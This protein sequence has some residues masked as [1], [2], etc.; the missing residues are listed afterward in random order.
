MNLVRNP[1]A[2]LRH[3]A[4][5]VTRI[6]HTLLI[7]VLVVLLITGTFANRAYSATGDLD[8]TFGAGGIVTTDFSDSFDAANAVALQSDGKIVAAGTTIKDFGS[9]FTQ[10]FAVARYNTDGSLDNGFGAGGKVTTDFSGEVDAANAI[11]LQSDGKILVAGFAVTGRTMQFPNQDFALARYNSNG[12]LDASFGTGGKVTTD[13]SGLFDMPLAIAIQNDGKIVLAGSDED[14][15]FHARFALSRYNSNG[16]LD[17][18]FGSGGKITSVYPVF[19]QPL[20]AAFQS[21]NKIVVAGSTAGLNDLV[22]DFL[23]TRYHSDGSVD[24]SFGTGGNTTT[25]FFGRND[26]ANSIAIQ[27]DGKI[28]AGGRANISSDAFANYEFALSRYN[29]EGSLDASFGTGGKLTIGFGGNDDECTAIAI[30]PNGKIVT[31]G[32][33]NAP[34]LIVFGDRHF[35]LARLNSDGGLDSGFGTGARIVT[36]FGGIDEIRALAI[37]SDGKIIAAGVAGGDFALSRYIGAPPFDVC[38]QDDSSGDTLKINSTTGD[39][40][41]TKCGG[42]VLSGMGTLIKRGSIITLQHY[43]PD[44]RVLATIDNAVNKGFASIQVF[45]QGTTFTIT[46]RNTTNNTCACR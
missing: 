6:F 45:S 31:G 21:D 13:F 44:R 24:T 18:T 46:D 43:G 32:F 5:A 39:Y 12:S 16:S 14:F 37:Q 11:A 9:A 17:I 4:S 38:L 23:L 19:V 8:P 22:G 42:L 1:L 20:A 33:T 10:D 26:Q 28:V 30:Q 15:S 27:G 2:L 25:D 3:P 36:D 35:A 29:T 7:L 34:P 40:Q 41:F